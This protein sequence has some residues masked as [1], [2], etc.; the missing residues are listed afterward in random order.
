[1]TIHIYIYIYIYINYKPKTICVRVRMWNVFFYL[2]YMLSI[3][4]PNCK[5]YFYISL[6]VAI[7]VNYLYFYDIILQPRSKWIVTSY[8]LFLPSSS[9]AKDPKGTRMYHFIF[10][11]CIVCYLILVYLRFFYW[12]QYISVVYGKCDTCNL[13]EMNLPANLL[14]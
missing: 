2:I 9:W 1:M 14:K 4:I 10:L 12:E 6:L 7:L 11:A 5:W 8:I 3:L 13:I